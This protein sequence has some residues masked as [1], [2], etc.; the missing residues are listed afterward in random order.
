MKRPTFKTVSSGPFM[1]RIM[2][3]AAYDRACARAN[4][5]IR[6]ALKNVTDGR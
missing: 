6:R 1:A 4:E 5:E 2:S 3:R